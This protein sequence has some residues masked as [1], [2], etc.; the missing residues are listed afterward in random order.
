MKVRSYILNLIISI[1]FLS[2]CVY[3]KDKIRKIEK[4]SFN[5]EDASEW[6]IENVMESYYY[7]PLASNNE[8]L[9]KNIDRLYVTDKEI[10]VIDTFLGSIFIFD[11]KGNGKYKISA[12][13]KGPGEYSQLTDAFY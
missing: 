10:I 8:F 6:Y 3:Q 13:G 9:I 5:P 7:I 2:S 12:K 4:I 1:F 11:R